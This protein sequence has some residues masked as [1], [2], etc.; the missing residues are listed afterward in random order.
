MIGN[1]SSSNSYAIRPNGIIFVLSDWVM[2]LGYE[3]IENF[4]VISVVRDKLDSG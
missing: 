4:I 3:K 2:L 1:F